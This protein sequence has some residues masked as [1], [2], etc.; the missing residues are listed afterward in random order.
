MNVINEVT[1]FFGAFD[2]AL[3]VLGALLLIGAPAFVAGLWAGWRMRKR[4]EPEEVTAAREI[5]RAAHEELSDASSRGKRAIRLL[6]AAR[7]MDERAED[8]RRDARSSRRLGIEVIRNNLDVKSDSG[9]TLV[10]D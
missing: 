2:R 7:T 8:L 1:F 9:I 3:R 6:E 4:K 10:E 5:R